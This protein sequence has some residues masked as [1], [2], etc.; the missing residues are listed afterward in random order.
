[1]VKNEREGY[2][3]SG[4]DEEEEATQRAVAQSLA[5]MEAHDAQWLPRDGPLLR[6]PKCEMKCGRR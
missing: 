5:Q 4:Y 6:P 1:L 2:G 3:G